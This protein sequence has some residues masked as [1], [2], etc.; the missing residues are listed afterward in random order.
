M[1][2][3]VIVEGRNRQVRRLFKRAKIPL[4]RLTRVAIGPIELGDLPEGSSRALTSAEL[5]AC[6]TVHLPGHR[7]H[8]LLPT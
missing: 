7:R 4:T 1:I 6:L 8:Q 3:V 2:E 5:A